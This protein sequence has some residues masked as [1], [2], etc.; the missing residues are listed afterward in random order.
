VIL[1]HNAGAGEDN[2]GAEELESVVAAAGHEVRYSSLKQEGWEATLEDPA[3]LVVV[4]GGDGSVGRVFTELATKDVPVT[5]LPVGSANNVARTLGLADVPVGQL[6]RGWADGRLG[7]FDIGEAT[8]PWGTAQFVE[9]IGGG[10]FGEVLEVADEIDA[11]EAEGDE[12]VTLGLE[13][14]RAVIDAAPALRWEVQ[15]DGVDFS[16]E[17]LGLEVTN[18]REIGPNFPL[19]PKADPGDGLLDVVLVGTE[20]R[21]ALTGYFEDRLA[22]V[23]PRRQRFSTS[24]G[25]RVVV[26]PPAETSLHVDD[27]FWPTDPSARGAGSAVVTASASVRLLLPRF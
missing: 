21:D 12:K 16:G 14:M 8:A 15:V 5:L 22:G 10:I 24:R 11:E 25:A 26:R 18:I 2:H 23:E 1:L 13:L 4:A 19:A 27:E 20:Q 3:D 17:F 6:V 7:R 9:S